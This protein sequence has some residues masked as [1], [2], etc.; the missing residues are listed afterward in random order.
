MSDVRLFQYL[1][2]R[3]GPNLCSKGIV[4]VSLSDKNLTPKIPRDCLNLTEENDKNIFYLLTNRNSYLQF[5]LKRNISIKIIQIH[6]CVND[7]A[8]PWT[9]HP[10]SYSIQFSIDNI[11]YENV[12][13]EIR[14][15]R[16]TSSILDT[17]YTFSLKKKYRY[18]RL[19]MTDAADGVNTHGLYMSW[20]EFFTDP[21]DNNC[22]KD[23]FYACFHSKLL[24]FI[25]SI[26]IVL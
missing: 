8:Y 6:G 20:I 16:I 21:F 5:D 11:Q 13:Q 23:D 24:I 22:S 18:I 12:Y 25:S 26:I 1:R 2:N 19:I 3:H 15:Q 4:N 9:A 17:F 7:Y 14:S 10:P